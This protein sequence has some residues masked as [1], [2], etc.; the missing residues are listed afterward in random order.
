RAHNEEAVIGALLRSL[1]LQ[2][3]PPGKQRVYVVANNCTDLTAAVVRGSGVAVCHERTNGDAATKG[4]ALAWLWEQVAAAEASCD[5][6]L[7]LDA[8]NMVA[9]DFLHEMNAIF[10]NGYWV[11]QSARCAKNAGDTWTSQLDAISEA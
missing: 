9:P 11:V 10:E 6:V 1:A 2:Q 8:D 3:Y 5:C 4:A 7:V